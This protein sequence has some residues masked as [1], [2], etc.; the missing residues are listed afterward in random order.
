MS[1]QHFPQQ[2]LDFDPFAVLGVDA[3]ADTVLIQLAYRARIR[4]AHPDIAGPA[5]LEQTKRLN[6]ARD[7]LLDPE[8][9]ARLLRPATRPQPP[10]GRPQR[11]TRAAP[12]QEAPP[13]SRARPGRRPWARPAPDPLSAF[14]TPDL[15]P[16]SGELHA[17]LATVR[18]LTPDERAR[19]NYALGDQRPVDIDAY[20]DYLGP[21]LWSYSLALRDAVAAAW[22]VGLDEAPPLVE[23]LGRLHP[24]G[25]LVAN[26]NA[27]WI[28]L[29]DFLQQEL[30]GGAFGSEHIIAS[31]A[32]RCAGPWQASIGQARYGPN[33]PHV[34]RFLHAAS[35]LTADAGKRLADGWRRHA[36]SGT[37]GDGRIGPGVWLPA[38]PNYPDVLKISGYLAAVDASRIVPPTG[39]AAADHDA[40]RYG[41]RLTAHAL[42]LGLA[43]SAGRDYLGPW[44]ETL[45]GD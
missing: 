16:R 21:Q 8:L 29:G 10:H 20:E 17:F 38:P 43:G 22:S 44:R 30:R 12:T 39:L 18:D 3:D 35:A 15:G 24:S 14:G 33:Q 9:R 37:D 2:P 42:A 41:L 4:L 11:P 31:F 26:A 5:G 13:H 34:T 36:G 45:G 19:V 28:L 27:Q 7:W 23:P 25:F 6:T 1:D 32:A 40:F